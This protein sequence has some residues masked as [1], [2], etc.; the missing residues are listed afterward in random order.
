MSGQSRKIGIIA[1]GGDLPLAVARACLAAGHS[2]ALY[3]ISEFVQ[4]IP[5]DIDSAS[6]TISK[7]GPGIRFLKSRHCSHLVFV[8]SFARPRD[9]NIRIRPDFAAIKFLVRNFGVLRRSNDGI[10]RA[11]ASEFERY[12]FRVISPLDAAP[13]LAANAGCLTS[14]RPAAEVEASFPAAVEAARDHGRTGEGQAIIYGNGTVLARE[15]RAGTDA[16][17][18]GIGKDEARNAFLVK[19]MSPE[20]LQTMD[21][22]AIGVDTVRLAAAQGLSGILVEAGKSIIV[23]PTQVREI[24][25]TAGLFV[26]GIQVNP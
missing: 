13:G 10:H 3:G 16:M 12:G 24:A 6:G 8:G 17:L 21:P 9:R 22:P 2:V 15:T 1:G 4:D 23:N 5:P 14:A 7:L 19:T 18:R 11:F 20:Q 26:C 25:D